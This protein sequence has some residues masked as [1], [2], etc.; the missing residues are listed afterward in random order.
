M[1][2]A[3]LLAG[4]PLIDLGPGRGEWLELW[5][6]HGSAP[7]YGIEK[8]EAMA[9]H[10]RGKGLDVRVEDINEHLS[11]LEGRIDFLLPV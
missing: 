2:L 11:K 5:R 8:S 9:E 10:C 1:G 6:E 7:A 4:L 3:E